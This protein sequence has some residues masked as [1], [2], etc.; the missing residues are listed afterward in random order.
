MSCNSRNCLVVESWPEARRRPRRCAIRA[1]RQC[2][3]KP[4]DRALG[5]LGPGRQRSPVRNHQGVGG[6]GKGR[7]QGRL[8]HQPGQQAAAHLGGRIAGPLRPR[9]H[10]VHQ[11]GIGAVQRGARARRRRREE[12]RRQERT[13]RSGGRI[14]RQVRGQV[15]GRAD[16]A[17][18]AAA[19]LLRALRPDE[20]A[21]RRRRAG[22]LSGRQAA[23]GRELD[24]G[25]LPGGGRK[26]PEGRPRLR[27]AARQHHR[28]QPVGR[29]AVPGLWRGADGCQGQHHGQDGRGPPGAGVRQEARRLRARPTRRPG[30]TPRTTS[31]CSPA[32]AR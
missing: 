3:R 24:L 21:C 9:H 12:R 4:D 15:A 32:R 14:S 29:R 22:A 23:G 19:R 16:D 30:T 25:C 18:H 27:P 11:L 10:G 20:G 8:H 13:D 17:R 7:R 31:G 26:V 2:G 28:H 1:Q 6:Q 5:P